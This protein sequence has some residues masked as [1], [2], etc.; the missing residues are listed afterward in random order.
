[1][2]AACK[3]PPADEAVSRI[4]LSSLDRGPSQPIPSPDSSTAIWAESKDPLRILYGN[5]GAPPMLALACMEQPGGPVI[6]ITRYAAADKDAQAMLALIGNAHIARLP[7]DATPRGKALLWH[8][9][10]AASDPRLEVLTGRRAV[11]ATI[12]GAGMLT[13]NP[14]ALPRE[15]IETCRASTMA[16]AINVDAAPVR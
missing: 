11:T 6:G 13:L 7:V 3:P 8:G 12:P 5:P 16:G 10:I 9:T 2:L 14:S 4:D 15:L 1:M